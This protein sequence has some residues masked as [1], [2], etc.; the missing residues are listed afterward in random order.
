[1][2]V[3]QTA[4]ISVKI[5][6]LDSLEHSI[7]TLTRG[8]WLLD[9]VEYIVESYSGQEVM[10]K[11]VTSIK[12][13]RE[14][15]RI[16]HYENEHGDMLTTEEFVA[17][18]KS[19]ESKGYPDE[20]SA[21]DIS[22][23]NLDDEY[24]YRKFR[25]EWGAKYTTTVGWEDVSTERTLIKL[26]T[27]NAFIESLYCTSDFTKED[28]LLY[29]YSRRSAINDIVNKCFESLGM[30]FKGKLEYTQTHS[31]KVWG[32]SD[33]STPRYIVA[34]GTYVFSNDFPYA[35]GVSNYKGTLEQCLALYNSD[36]KLYENHIKSKYSA[37][38][39]NKE[40]NKITTGMVLNKL[41]TIHRALIGVQPKQN[42]YSSFTTQK[43]EMK[44]LIDKLKEVMS[45]ECGE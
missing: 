1:M 21:Y 34:F 11:D 27:D 28:S 12:F 39:G 18:K 13:K 6:D 10:V 16:S 25:K 14:I 45:E 40:I 19:L 23:S 41:E 7:V 9:G 4:T 42:S 26:K 17:S 44:E 43:R 15:T 3:P 36:K 33:T 31:E 2:S 35:S 32:N 38:F 5:K 8:T 30:E 20:D 37:H 24:N 29:T 22:F